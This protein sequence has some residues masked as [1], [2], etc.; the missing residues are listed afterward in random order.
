MTESAGELEMQLRSLQRPTRPLDA[1]D[2]G[3][4]R[5]LGGTR[6]HRRGA[7]RLAAASVVVVALIGSAF[8]LGRRTAPV[9]TLS[10][11]G[12]TR[13]YTL[14]PDGV[15]A[16]PAQLDDTASILR[17]RLGA[18]GIDGATVARQDEVIEIT[19]PDGVEPRSITLVA[20]S[21]RVEFRGVLRSL[22]STVGPAATSAISS[23][24]T[25]APDDSGIL[26]DGNLR[27]QVGPVALTGGIESATARVNAQS[28]Q[29]I[30]NPVLLPGPSGIDAFNE[31]ASQC[32][33]KD[34]TVCPTG[35]LAMVLDGVVV[36]APSINAAQFGRDQIQISGPFN[37]E[38]AKS[39]AEQMGTGGLPVRLR[40]G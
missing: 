13:T 3:E 22:S 35:Q 23:G 39:I 20:I 24:T 40:V 12:T 25:L 21:H 27:Y 14:V 16:T 10:P 28:G 8:A 5:A 30:V 17:Q 29:W 1:G 19:V 7:W 36:A 6:D 34:L 26:D 38:T 11:G 15:P 31:I 32:Y 33:V 4:V 18:L 37:E 9:D 2:F